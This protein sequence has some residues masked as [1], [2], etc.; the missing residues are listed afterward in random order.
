MQ[1]DTLEA[2]RFAESIASVFMKVGW[3]VTWATR[4]EPATAPPA[5]FGVGIE[6]EGSNVSLSKGGSR[7]V[8]ETML[9]D[10]FREFG[11]SLNLLIRLH[12][13]GAKVPEFPPGF[14]TG[15]NQAEAIAS[16]VKIHVGAHP[17]GY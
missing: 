16:A 1:V 3:K 10:A 15:K 2:K 11:V 8:L 6:V 5:G 14:F 9:I 4:A 7:Y 13:P 17:R 12:W